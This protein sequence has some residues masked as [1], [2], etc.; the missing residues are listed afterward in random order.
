[1]GNQT[2]TVS[3][4]ASEVTASKAITITTN[5][6]SGGSITA[7]LAASTNGTYHLAQKRTQV[8]SIIDTN[9]PVPTGPVIELMPVTTGTIIEGEIANFNFQIASGST[10][11]TELEV[12]LEIVDSGNF[13]KGTLTNTVT[14]ETNGAGMKPVPTDDD[15][16][17]E[18]DGMITVTI[19]PGSLTPDNKNYQ[20]SETSA[21]ISQTITVQD[22]D[23]PRV[24]ISRTVG[25]TEE[26]TPN[27]NYR[28]SASPPPYQMITISL[29]IT[30]PDGL[31]NSATARSIVLSPTDATSKQGTILLLNSDEFEDIRTIT[32]QIASGTGYAPVGNSTLNADITNTITIA[33]LDSDYKPKVTLEGASTRNV[34]SESN[35]IKNFT[36]SEDANDIN[37][38]VQFYVSMHAPDYTEADFIVN[39]QVSER[40]NDNFLNEESEGSMML[41]LDSFEVANTNSRYYFTVVL[42]VVSDLIDEPDGEITF[43]V[44]EGD[45]YIIS[46]V[47]EENS[48]KIVVQDNDDPPILSITGPAD[49]ATESD[50][51]VEF[52]VISK[53]ASGVSVETAMPI[54]I[55]YTV[56]DDTS[57]DFLVAEEEGDKNTNPVSFTMNSSGIFTAPIRVN[58]DNDDTT[59]RT[60]TITVTLRPDSDEKVD[61]TVD[62]IPRNQATAKIWD[63][64][65]PELTI[66]G[67]DPVNEGDSE[68]KA[69]FTVQSR[70]EVPN[71]GSLT[72]KYTPENANIIANSGT[73]VEAALQFSDDDSD[74]IYTA[75][76]EIPVEQDDLSEANG[77]VTVT[78]NE[79]IVIVNSVN[80]FSYT[81]GT[82]ASAEVFVRDDDIPQVSISR[83]VTPVSES[84][85]SVTYT[86][87]AT[88]VPFQD[89]V[90]EVNIS[91]TGSVISGTAVERIDMTTSGLA[92]GTIYLVDD[93]ID[94]AES[95]ITIQ[96]T[97]NT[98]YDPVSNSTVNDTNPTNTITIAVSDNDIPQVSITGGAS[99]IEDADAMFTL[100]ADPMPWEDITINVNLTENL[101][102]VTET[103]NLFIGANTREVVM[104]TAD[105]GTKNLSVDLNDLSGGTIT[106]TVA[107]HSDGKYE[108]AT[109]GVSHKI[110]VIDPD[111]A[112]AADAPVIELEPASATP[113]VEGA[114]AVFNLRV[115]SG[116]TIPSGPGLAVDLSIEQDGIFIDET[117][118]INNPVS[119]TS[120][121]TSSV[122]IP[123]ANDNIDEADGSITVTILIGRINPENKNYRIS[124]T[125]ENVS[126]TIMVQDNDDPRISISRIDES[127]SESRTSITYTLTAVPGPYQEIS[128]A[129]NITETGATI[130]ETPN[131]MIKMSTSGTVIGEVLLDDDDVNETNSTVTIQVVSGAGYEP[132]SNSTPNENLSNTITVIVSDNDIPELTIT[133]GADVFIQNSPIA[134]FIIT[135]N[136]YIFSSLTVRYT[137]VSENFL[138]QHESGT[139]KTANLF[140]NGKTRTAILSIVVKKDGVDADGTVKVTLESFG[141]NE[142]YT[143]STQRSATV[144]VFNQPNYVLSISDSFVIEGASPANP[145]MTF[146]VILSPAT[147]AGQEVSLTWSTIIGF[148]DNATPSVDFTTKM[149]E[150]LTFKAGE[151]NKTIS[152]EIKGDDTYEP[153]ESF[154]IIFNNPS[155]FFQINL[156]NARAKGR[157]INDDPVNEA[158]K[159]SEISILPESRIVTEGNPAIF[160]FVSTSDLP[161]IG[162]RLSIEVTEFGEFIA[163]RRPQSFHMLEN[164]DSMK[165]QTA[166]DLSR[167]GTNL[168]SVRIISVPEPYRVAEGSESASVTVASDDITDSTPGPRISIASTAV[169]SILDIVNTPQ[170]N[171]PPNLEAE[172]APAIERPLVS[173]TTV[174]NTI[175]EGATARFMIRSRNGTESTNISVS[176]QVNHVRAQVELPETMNVQLS[177]QDAVSIAIPTINNDHADK[178]GYIAVSLTEDPSY[179]I[180]EDKG[181]AVVNISDAIDRQQR[182]AEITAH[183]QAFF[184]DLTGRMGASNLGIV[185]NRITQGFSENANQVLE[186]GGRNSVTGILTASGEAINENTTTLKSF[187]GDSSFAM[188]LISGDEFAIPTT[189]WGLGDYQ[190]LSP[191]GRNQTIDWS[192]DLFTGHIGIDTLINEGLLTGISASVSE[193]EIE[194]IN[195]ATDALQFDVRTTS[196]NPY[197][198]WTSQ[199]RNSELRATFGLGQG[200]IGIKQ[201]SYNDTILDSKSY[202]IGLNGN[203]VLFTSNNNSNGTTKLSIKG[204]SWFAH[205]FIAG[206]DGILTEIHTN[207]QHL[208]IRTEGSHQFDF[209]SGSTFSPLISIGVRNDV[210]DHQSV[211]GV[212]LTSGANYNN[213][214]GLTITGTGSML[215]GQANQLQKATI[216]SSLNYDRGSDNLGFIVDVSP[217]WGYVDVNIQDT[218]WSNNILDTNFEN[219]QYSNGVSLVS[220]FGYGLNILS[221][222]SVLTPFSGIEISENQSYE[223]LIG[224][225]LGLGSNAN[226]ELSG[227]QRNNT[228]GTNSTAVR[229]NGSLNW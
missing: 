28:L 92:M 48:I 37:G 179:L 39:Y 104:M 127:V 204:D 207:A 180:A 142:I 216:N 25:H 21:K 18:A 122:S 197:L 11:T 140:F 109:S 195:S 31:I 229:L 199:N 10:V 208:R 24:S 191:I 165:I 82:P 133:A 152:V 186:L 63:D 14:I 141:N 183:A 97:G 106:V 68:P 198:G 56:A 158:T 168:I 51:V 223:Y 45:D 52:E 137:P 220:E 201:E 15:G 181:D 120:S 228:S 162:L 94:E 227:I 107:T 129:V 76:I 19:L 95:T 187:L 13:I 126:Q 62:I 202:S 96:V 166:N 105:N 12:N 77:N 178:N 209:A 130:F 185:S 20:L 72:V 148:G 1:M 93:D 217:K 134:N 36:I 170:T 61:Y 225:R 102:D 100:S 205:Q 125:L 149:N 53:T 145:K 103:G 9:A 74:G 210:K 60:G 112:P 40:A 224:T 206:R 85:S 65:A 73:Q 38:P 117:Q 226:F 119:I 54:T 67:G 154:T 23:I 211:L 108:P 144:N 157:I 135:S 71:N 203:Q 66:I 128:I 131:S 90:I 164:G 41:D 79:T 192:G 29:T 150:A 7:S 17:D 215:V 151:S 218:L 136:K 182:Q 4:L 213:P 163:W 189:L 177:G 219:G 156:N 173:I 55:Y 3:F 64:D 176:F 115:A 190:N 99:V 59:E 116:S 196:L 111:S 80:T 147:A 146:E 110:L 101:F 30:A 221:G 222:D 91:E 194:F 167:E 6:E 214:I 159:L 193:S 118:T 49:G 35:F 123:T 86:L 8:T 89:I 212:E 143:I 114:P 78:L 42:F 27:L 88:P 153:H 124:D 139:T 84:D 16:S 160:T 69:I 32:I 81:I 22:N 184:P 87:T 200:E 113:I 70:V 44:L 34:I 58:V 46:D 33:V 98:G 26:D 83:A 2:Q 75:T 171:T 188:S 5:D 138:N 50:A 174:N 57:G 132:V 43:T 155:D 161:D 169:D 172:S 121:G 175:D 47:V